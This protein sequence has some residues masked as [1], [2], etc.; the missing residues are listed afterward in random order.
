M[1]K[2][3]VVRHAKSSWTNPTETDA[4]RGLNPRGMRDISVMANK[5]LRRNLCPDIC[6]F[7]SS[8]RTRLTAI[9]LLDYLQTDIEKEENS[10]LYLANVEQIQKEI[11]TAFLQYDFVML[12]GHNPGL[13]DF[14][15]HSTSLELDNLPTLGMFLVSFEKWPLWHGKFH[16][17]YYPKKIF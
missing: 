10:S 1:K 16:F 6:L 4:E 7:S 11:S 13:T 5:L 8:N 17:L 12:V 14:F 3:L 2:L 15:N 9:A